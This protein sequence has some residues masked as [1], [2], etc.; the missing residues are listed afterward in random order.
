[1]PR[2]LVTGGTGFLGAHLATALERAGYSVR[3]LDLHPPERGGVDGREFV[4]ADVR[5][6]AR[7][8]RAMIGC[9]VVVDNAALVPV[10]RAAPAEYRS[11][12]VD[13][14]RATLDAA[15]AEGAYVLHISSSAI[16]GVPVELPV[17][18]DTPLAP[19]EPYGRSKAEA[20]R[21]VHARRETGLTVASLRPRT[22]LGDGR[23]GL[24]DVIFARVQRG[25]RVPIFGRGLNQ[26]QM[27]DVED[28][29]AAAVAAV[30]RRANGDYNIG[31]AGYGTVREDLQELIDRVGSRSR[32]QPV[33][34]WAIRAVLRPLDAVGRSP[35]NEWHWRSA[36]E[37]FYFDI[38]RAR[39]ELGW[40]P[41]RTNADALENA[42]RHY[43]RRAGETGSSAHRRPLAGALARILRG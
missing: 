25:R 22:L 3:T 29:C 6:R 11:V 32:L 13:G 15:E 23:L 17:T 33:P 30:E 4:Q 35:F 19:F 9:E 16:Y 34:A 14:C 10:S 41:R 38:S 40:N 7:L 39:D 42:F 28:F 8:R 5:D 18:T 21:L 1:M 27:C 12:N 2:A 26:V 36:P 43:V 24:F 31:S 37:P 20:E